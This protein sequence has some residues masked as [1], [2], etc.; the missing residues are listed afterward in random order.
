MSGELYRLLL[1]II[2]LGGLIPGLIYLW[3]YGRPLRRW[4]SKL[5]RGYSGWVAIICLLYLWSLFRIVIAWARTSQVPRQPLIAAAFA[6]LIG[7]FL[8]GAMVQRLMMYLQV[9][10]EERLHP[11][12]TCPRCNG[13]GVI[14][15]KG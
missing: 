14:P 2:L 10:R 5:A 3:L 6:L 1:V 11:T 13:D 4:R 9:L 15:A 12:V 7:A 8:S